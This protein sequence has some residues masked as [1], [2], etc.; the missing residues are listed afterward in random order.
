MS[1]QIDAGITIDHAIPMPPRAYGGSRGGGRPTK[2]PWAS[3][4]IGDSFAVP[5]RD[6]DTAAK[7][8]RR[9]CVQ[10]AKRRHGFSFAQRALIENGQ[11][12]VRT[13]RTA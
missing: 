5:F 13:W 2:Y 12:V 6:G 8:M 4:K 9:V 7:A 3:M 1:E 10:A 11:R